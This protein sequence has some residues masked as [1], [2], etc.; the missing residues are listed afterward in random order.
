M[1]QEK[2]CQEY[3]KLGKS[4]DGNS[5]R[6]IKNPNETGDLQATTS[7]GRRCADQIPWQRGLLVAMATE[8]RRRIQTGVYPWRGSPSV[9]ILADE[10]VDD[11]WTS[12]RREASRF[13]DRRNLRKGYTGGEE[14]PGHRNDAQ[15]KQKRNKTRSQAEQPTQQHNMQNNIEGWQRAG[16]RTTKRN[17]KTT[18]H[19]HCFESLRYLWQYILPLL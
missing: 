9:D 13:D 18:W 11:N 19:T 6:Q 3:E 7:G 5:R 10:A 14:K 1:E 16:H 15:T 4:G 2:V 8:E 17:T 12:W